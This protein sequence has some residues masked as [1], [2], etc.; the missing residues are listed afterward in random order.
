MAEKSGLLGA[1][2]VERC[3]STA[4]APSVRRYVALAFAPPGAANVFR[5]AASG[6]LDQSR[7]DDAGIRIEETFDFDRV[8]PAVAKEA[9]VIGPD[10]RTNTAREYPAIDDAGRDEHADAHDAKRRKA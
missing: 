1:A 8:L 10:Q 6:G 4:K 2:C 5:R 7:I 3:S 9:A